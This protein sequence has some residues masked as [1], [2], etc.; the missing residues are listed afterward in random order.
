MIFPIFRLTSARD[1]IR[2]ETI[3]VANVET[4]FLSRIRQHLN[5]KFGLTHLGLDL[6][7]S[8]YFW[9]T[10]SDNF[11]LSLTAFIKV[12]TYPHQES[13]LFLSISN[14]LLSFKSPILTYSFLEK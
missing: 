9:S 5:I 7:N 4:D 1:L 12:Y 6:A 14:H 11:M 3:K 8:F 2:N 10:F 13:T